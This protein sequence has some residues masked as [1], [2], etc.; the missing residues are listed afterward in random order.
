M[1]MCVLGVLC[2]PTDLYSKLPTPCLFRYHVKVVPKDEDER[3]RFLNAHYDDDKLNEAFELICLTIL[4]E[5][6]SSAAG[7]G[8][9]GRAYRT[10]GT[11]WRDFHDGKA[12]A[13]E[14]TLWRILE[15]VITEFQYDGIETPT[16]K[17]IEGEVRWLFD[18][19]LKATSGINSPTHD[20]L[21]QFIRTG[22]HPQASWICCHA[23]ASRLHEIAHLSRR[24][25]QL[26]TTLAIRFQHSTG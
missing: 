15:F 1:S 9:D 10:V 26:R 20:A 7:V 22:A 5:L 3:S 16:T 19:V 4:S 14:G 24:R 8:H 23:S 6:E 25:L 2:H 13:H 21:A 11:M 17:W 12:N 18:Q